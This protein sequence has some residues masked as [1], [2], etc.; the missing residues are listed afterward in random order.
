MRI[1]FTNAYHMSGFTE[2]YIITKEGLGVFHYSYKGS[3]GQNSELISGFLS[4]I[5]SF[6]EELGWP[7]GVG[8][9]RAKGLECRIVPGDIVF[10]AVLL[11]STSGLGVMTDPILNDLAEELL[12]S[13]EKNFGEQLK[14]DGKYI[15]PKKY[16]K[17]EKNCHEVIDLQRDQVYELYQ[18][19]CLIESIESKVPQ[20]WCLPLMEELSSGVKDVTPKFKDI[21]QKYPHMKRVIERINYSSAPVWDIF[22]IPL[23]PVN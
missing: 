1:L 19:L 9:I 4:A 23:Y 17:F 20:K 10:C 8:L 7:S 21:I 15:E 13:F 14:K 11:S 3:S 12:K 2:I 16:T 22:D 18:K 5:N 6:A